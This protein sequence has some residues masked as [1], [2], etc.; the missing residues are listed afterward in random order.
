[1]RNSN[2]PLDRPRIS[3]LNEARNALAA[4]D[5]GAES[6][7]IAGGWACYKGSDPWIN[8]LCGVNEAL[9]PDQLD[10]F[11][12]FYAERGV[13]AK[14][15]ISTMAA[16]PLLEQLTARG[17]GLLHFEN[18]F[19]RTLDPAEDPAF[20]VS[21]PDACRIRQTDPADREACLAHGRI[22]LSGFAS[23]DAP[24]FEEMVET[25]A[26]AIGIERSRGFTAEIA[27]EPAAACGMELWEVDGLKLCGLWGATVLEPFRRRGLQQALIAHRLAYARSW[28]CT[29]ALIES[30][31]GIP[32]ERNAARLGFQLAYARAVLI[33]LD[34]SRK[35]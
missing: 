35:L 34:G 8:R 20:G 27:G 21:V 23:P 12:R 19:A 7:S 16:E 3:Q 31:P 1:M 6:I 11:E 18:V 29:L 13:A 5:L 10:R 28:G 2:A 26:D 32:T 30:K 4:K 17:F 14:I 25:S 33:R 15:E 22:A 24:N 9:T